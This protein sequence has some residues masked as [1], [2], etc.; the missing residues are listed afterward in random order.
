MT[1]SFRNCQRK[2]K[3][4]ANTGVSPLRFASVEMT[5]CMAGARRK[6]KQIPEGNDNS[7]VNVNVNVYVYGNGRQ[8][9][10]Q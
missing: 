4:S 6:Q 7:N 2:A 3:A 9:Q 5:G 1:I 8:G 10:G